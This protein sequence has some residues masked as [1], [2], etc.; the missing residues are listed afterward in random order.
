METCLEKTL[1]ANVSS[2]LLCEPGE[3]IF[4]VLDNQNASA[5]LRVG[6]QTRITVIGTNAYI[7][8]QGSESR[9]TQTT[10]G[11][12][13]IYNFTL[14]TGSYYIKIKP[15]DGSYDVFKTNFVVETPIEISTDVFKYRTNWNNINLAGSIFTGNRDIS[16][17][18]DAVS[19]ENMSNGLNIKNTNIVGNISS[20]DSAY[21][22]YIQAEGTLVSGTLESIAAA[23]VA[24][25]RTSGTCDVTCNGVI[26]YNG[27]PVTGKYR[28][29]FTGEGTGYTIA[30]V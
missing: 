24:N 26:T 16:V 7:K 28:I 11:G 3:F 9:L 18:K 23:M 25:G 21:I 6:R 17:F 8:A 20:I 12:N 5:L 4:K 2:D 19:G 13:L 29:T 10:T 27:S 15:N 1:K 14:S 30:I 22:T